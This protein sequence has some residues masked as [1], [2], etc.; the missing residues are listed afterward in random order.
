MF[1][2]SVFQD[3]YCVIY[4]IAFRRRGVF[5]VFVRNEGY[6]SCANIKSYISLFLATV[7]VSGK[8]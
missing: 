4:Y 8:F 7:F 1:K 5:I 3:P 6:W 2:L